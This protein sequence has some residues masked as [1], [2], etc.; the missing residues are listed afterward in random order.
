MTSFLKL[1]P[2]AFVVFFAIDM[3]WLG[4]IAK[5][6]YQREIGHLL[7][8][9]VN[10]TAAIIFY[11]VFIGG[12][13]L[14]VLMPAVQKNIDQ[15]FGPGLLHA[16]IFGALLGFLTYATYDLTNLATLKDWP[17]RITLID[18]SWGTFLGLSTSTLTYLLYTLIY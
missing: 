3:I 6:L 14:F 15:G 16:L 1:Y 11:L 9:D 8:K 13:V 12:L 10:W 2:I 18:L 7:K 5:N 4:L 17:L